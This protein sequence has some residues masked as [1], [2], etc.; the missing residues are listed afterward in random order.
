[1]ESLLIYIF[2]P[3]LHLGSSYKH[4]TFLS[5]DDFKLWYD[6]VLMPA[7]QATVRDA[8][9]L[10]HYPVSAEVVTVDATV[11]S[12]ETFTKKSTSREQLLKYALQPQHLNLI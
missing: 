7:I 10:Q 11:L 6:G 3:E 1:M 12:G 9:I 2:F 8:N 4:S 5:S